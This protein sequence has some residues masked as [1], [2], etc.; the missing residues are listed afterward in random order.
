MNF[1]V[2]Q[3]RRCLPRLSALDKCDLCLQV[4][5]RILP[6]P[7]LK[8]ASEFGAPSAGAWNLRNGVKFHQAAKFDS[9]AVASFASQRDVGSPGPEGFGVRA[10]KAVPTSALL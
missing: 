3:A 7:A 8:Y 9:Y 1:H 4:G 10:V 2:L 6:P 5:G